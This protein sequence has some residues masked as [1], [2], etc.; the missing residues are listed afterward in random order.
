MCGVLV[1]GATL[2]SSH[3]AAHHPDTLFGRTM[4]TASNL[5]AKLSPASGFGPVLAALQ[6]KPVA[7]D[8]VEGIPDD[9]EPI[10]AAMPAPDAKME[11]ATAAPIV[12]PENDAEPAEPHV[13]GA[14][15][16]GTLIQPVQHEQANFHP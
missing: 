5:A 4:H 10:E 13:A 9:P 1:V 11:V 14:V 7:H 2:C 3:S 12:I 8:E 15:V 16:E 6:K